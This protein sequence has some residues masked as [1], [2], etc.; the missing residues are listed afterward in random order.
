MSV[1]DELRELLDGVP[2]ERLD[3]VL[4]YVQTLQE[5]DAAWN[6][7]QGQHG[8]AETDEYIRTAVAEAEADPR[9]SVSHEAV[10]QWLRSWG[11]EDE[12]PPPSRG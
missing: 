5:A 3:D 6:A 2:D 12:L 10:A 9:A 7:W 11:T 8:S 4:V 1:R